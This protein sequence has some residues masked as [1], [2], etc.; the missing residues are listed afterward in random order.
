MLRDSYLIN[1]VLGSC[2]TVFMVIAFGSLALRISFE[3]LTR[4][5]N[6][7]MILLAGSAI[8]S[9]VVFFLCT[10][11]WAKKGVFVWLGLLAYALTLWLRSRT[12]KTLHSLSHALRLTR[13]QR[14]IGLLVFLFFGVLYLVHA[15][16]PEFS[17]DGATYHLG[18]VARWW[19]LWGFDEYRG[20][21]YSMWSQG[22]ELLF[23]VGFSVGKHSAAAVI[24]WLFAL[25]LPF[26]FYALGCRIG[27]TWAVTASGLMILASPVVGRT[28]SSAYNE[29][30]LACIL[31]GVYLLMEIWRVDGKAQVLMLA[32][33]LAGFAFAVKY[34]GGVALL[35]VL[36]VIAWEKRHAKWK[37]LVRC[38]AMACAFAAVCSLPWLLRSFWQF[39]NPLI[40][41]AN[42]WFPNPYVHRSFEIEYSKALSLYPDI[43]SRWQLPWKWAVEGSAVG[44]IFGPW[45]LLMPLGLL[46]TK[47]ITVRRLLLAALVMG[48][49]V[50]LNCG[51]RFLL[52]AILFMAPATLITIA[53]LGVRPIAV[54]VVHAALSIPQMVSLYCGPN[55]WRFEDFPWR[56]ALRIETEGDFLEKKMGSFPIAG[57]IEKLIPLQ[58]RT[59]A[60]FQ[61]PLAYTT[62][63]IWH[64]WQSAEAEI[65]YRVL[66]YGLNP[67][68][69]ES[70]EAQFSFAGRLCTG[71][72][73][74]ALSQNQSWFNVVEFVPY[75][76]GSIVNPNQS[77]RASAEPYRW[78]A[79]LAVDGNSATQWGSW[80]PLTKGNY[81]ELTFASTYVDSLGVRSGGLPN[82][83]SWG[84]EVRDSKGGW[85]LVPS[86]VNT[87]AL[88]ANPE[89]RRSS[90]KAMRS[91]GFTHLVINRDDKLGKDILERPA[92]WNLLVL[93]W[94]KDAAILE[95]RE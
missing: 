47:D 22:L 72:R 28:A 62:R 8:A 43:A 30:A 69:E 89:S 2:L 16:A 78:E 57:E 90:A 59:F 41:F 82:V 95:I 17:P 48:W 66:L 58:S 63:R 54:L 10:F 87:I 56:A 79:R 18:N 39:G 27:K 84:V 36:V 70:Q 42:A 88:K 11:H 31:V 68:A 3:T 15:V 60:N 25:M 77:W 5:E 38:L 51:T 52:P 81:L 64:N 26:L 20:S 23:L 50:F 67:S 65:A 75:A 55:T 4:L 19:K 12:P 76:K 40:P 85:Q 32:G 13:D 9:T 80:G 45:I 74:V 92:D 61:V 1:I 53:R 44:G 21:I 93:G 71:V 73:L 24:H 14:S 37:V 94:A 35:Y 7:L 33:F 86:R 49:P 34:T 29:L 83:D 46:G 91:L 6:K